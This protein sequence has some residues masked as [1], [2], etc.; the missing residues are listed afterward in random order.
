MSL[1]MYNVSQSLQMVQ[2]HQQ[3]MRKEFTR[4]A[5]A[6]NVAQAQEAERKAL[7]R[8]QI[9]YRV[10]HWMHRMAP[11]MARAML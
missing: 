6:R 5:V 3:E 10:R 7:R 1:N 4:I 8:F 11:R 9:M 2:L